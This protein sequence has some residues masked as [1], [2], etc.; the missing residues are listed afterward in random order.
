MGDITS[1]LSLAGSVNNGELRNNSTSLFV[2]H[3]ANFHFNSAIFKSTSVCSIDRDQENEEECLGSVGSRER[4]SR[5][6]GWRRREAP[7]V[8]A[9]A[10]KVMISPSDRTFTAELT[11]VTRCSRSASMASAASMKFVANSVT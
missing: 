2:I 7:R 1:L 11:T 9:A 8:A 3:D 6:W 5:P 4:W 10:V